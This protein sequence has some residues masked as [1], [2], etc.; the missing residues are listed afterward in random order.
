MIHREEKKAE[1]CEIFSEVQWRVV[2]GVN[3]WI[4]PEKIESINGIISTYSNVCYLVSNIIFQLGKLLEDDSSSSLCK[5]TFF[6][7]FTLLVSKNPG[8]FPLENG[9]ISYG[10]LKKAANKFGQ[11]NELVMASLLDGGFGHWVKKPEGQDHFKIHIEQSHDNFL[12]YK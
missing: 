7:R 6:Q 1:I 11:T 3:G 12:C 9:R 2:T 10:S 4:Q 8:W 5:R